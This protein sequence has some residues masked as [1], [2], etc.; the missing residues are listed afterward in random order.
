MRSEIVNS[1]GFGS[2]V[3]GIA[4]SANKGGKSAVAAVFTLAAIATAL[5]ALADLGERVLEIEAGDLAG[6]L[7]ARGD[8]PPGHPV[9]AA[10]V[11]LMREAMQVF[12][13]A[14][15]GD[16]AAIAQLG[17]AWSTPI[18]DNQ[19]DLNLP[20][21]ALRIAGAMH[22]QNEAREGEACC[23][24]CK[25]DPDHAGPVVE[26]PPDPLA[27]VAPAPPVRQTCGAG[28]CAQRIYG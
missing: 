2:L 12:A 3:Q 26:E 13:A 6:R 22:E 18:V 24:E 28:I 20:A 7:R 8:L 27:L 1:S 17:R 25:L 21:A 23:V 11:E 5:G 10:D 9:E 15:H 19:G 4:K 14:E 16:E